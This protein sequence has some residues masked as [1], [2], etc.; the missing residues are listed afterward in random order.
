MNKAM[1]A[2][3]SSRVTEALKNVPET[4]YRFPCERC[5]NL[6]R[7]VVG[8]QLCKAC[9]HGALLADHMHEVRGGEAIAPAA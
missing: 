6:A 5:P 2:A 4:R 3:L 8:T 1:M 7:L 9:V